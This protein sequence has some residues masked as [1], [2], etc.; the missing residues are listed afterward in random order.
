MSELTM[1]FLAQTVIIGMVIVAAHVATKVAIAKLEVKFDTLKE[2]HANA[3]VE[4]MAL[5]KQ[6]NGMSRNLA[7]ISGELKSCPH[8]VHGTGE[9]G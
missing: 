2:D 3:R 1:F 9:S 6:V 7:A 5:T 4:R 8:L